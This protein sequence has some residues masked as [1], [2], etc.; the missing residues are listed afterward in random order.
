V[1]RA[2]IA[3]AFLAVVEDPARDGHC[4]HLDTSP[5]I[6]DGWLDLWRIL[7]TLNL[8]SLPTLNKTIHKITKCQCDGQGQYAPKGK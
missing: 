5:R 2:T 8:F 3:F 1:G 4:R 7:M 6:R